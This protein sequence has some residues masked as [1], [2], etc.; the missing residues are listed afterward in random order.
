MS[1]LTKGIGTDVET[2][3]RMANESNLRAQA[4]RRDHDHAI[5]QL[6]ASLTTQ[7][8]RT[9]AL[10][11]ENM[12]LKNLLEN[13]KEE[14]ERDAQE[15]GALKERNE[16]LKE[17]LENI[18]R[19]M[20]MLDKYKKKVLYRGA[21]ENN[22]LQSQAVTLVESKLE[23]EKT[24]IGLRK[25]IVDTRD[26]YLEAER[27]CRALL[28]ESCKRNES[29]KEDYEGTVARLQQEIASLR[30]SLISIGRE[31]ERNANDGGTMKTNR[32][33]TVLK[34]EDDPV[35][36]M[37]QQLISNREKIEM[38]SRQNDRLSKTLCRLREYRG[39]VT[40]NRSNK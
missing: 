36:D 6:R 14:R 12:Q 38:L 25:E 23:L 10:H 33:D 19:Q 3:L 35:A 8:K 13:A 18:R 34:P 16:T 24:V 30:N 9:D 15:S 17:T 7:E 39:Q 22:I 26:A 27:R 4:A 5:R 31:N 28:D 32:E 37:T 11:A 2:A 21:G 40:T 20:S 1:R 29:L